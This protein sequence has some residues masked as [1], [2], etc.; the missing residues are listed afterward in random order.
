VSASLNGVSYGQDSGEHAYL[1]VVATV[2]AAGPTV[3]HTPAAGKRVQLRWIYVLPDPGA[4]ANPLIRVL[5][6]TEEKFRVYALSKRQLV[7]G[8]V[9]GALIVDLN[10]AASVAVTAILEEV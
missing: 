2:T 4:D 6:G 8:P 10:S 9:D 7:T 5:L 1:H 3:L